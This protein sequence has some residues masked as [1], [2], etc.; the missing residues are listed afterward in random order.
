[1]IKHQSFYS[2]I[3][4]YLIP[5]KFQ[6]LLYGTILKKSAFEFNTSFQMVIY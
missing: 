1:M 6:I 2:D 4:F 5:P 3:L